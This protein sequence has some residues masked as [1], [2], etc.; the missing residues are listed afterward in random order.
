[1]PNKA[2]KQS[3]RS[4]LQD[5]WYHKRGVMLVYIFLR[6]SVILV[7]VAQLFNRNFENVFLCVLV[8]FLF[9][10]PTMLEKRLSIE[11]PDT[12]E[13]IILLFIYA[14]EIMGEIGAYYIKHPYWDTVLHTL[15]GFL[16]AA[17]GFSL[18]DLLNRQK[19]I[20]FQLSPLYLAVVAFCFSMTVGILWEFFECTMDQLFFLDMQKDIIIHEI[21]TVKLDPTG[22]NTPIR[23]KDIVDVIVVQGDGTQT[24]LGL[25]GYLDIGLLDTMMDLFVNFVGAAVF[26][27]I[28]YFYVRSRGKNRFAKRFI[29]VVPDPDSPS[30]PTIQ[31]SDTRNESSAE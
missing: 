15:N 18:L 14:A 25:G 11:L 16:C 23:L 9:S 19:R 10:L 2:K 6:V 31:N 30:A 28:G 5:A 4:T 20:T 17:I 7:L 22:G 24:A 26:S 13:I 21:G 12:L 27:V 1:M 8:L 29:P 3:F